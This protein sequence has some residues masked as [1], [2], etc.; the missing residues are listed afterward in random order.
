MESILES[1]SPMEVVGCFLHKLIREHEMAKY[2]LQVRHPYRQL[3]RSLSSQASTVLNSCPGLSSAQLLA[4]IINSYNGVPE[5]FQLLRCQSSTSEAELHLFL[6]RVAHHPFQYMV[7]GVEKL[8]YDL[9][10]VCSV[11]FV[12]MLLLLVSFTHSIV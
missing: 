12:L 5:S 3:S 7:I 8:P 1:S 4:L 9:Q 11:A 6:E 2:A 10:E